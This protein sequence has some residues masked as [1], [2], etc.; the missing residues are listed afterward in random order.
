[1][2]AADTEAKAAAKAA[3]GDGTLQTICR[4]CD[5]HCGINV[6][7][8]NG[9][10]VKITGLKSHPQNEG[11]L[12]PKGPAAIDTVYHKDRLLKPLKKKP[13][14]SFEQI[15]L[16]QAMTEITARMLDIKSKHG[17]RAVACWQGE[18][19]GFA[20]QE[21]YARRFIHAFGSPNFFSCDSL[22]WAGRHLAYSLVQGYWNA[23]PDFLKASL[24]ILWGTNPPVSHSTF[25]GPIKEGRKK[26]AQLIVIDPRLTRIAKQADL[27]LR[28]LPGSDGA[29]AWGLVRHLIESGHHDTEFVRKYST[30]FEQFA[31]YSGVFT[32][33][34]VAGQTGLTAQE[35][36]TCCE[37]VVEHIPRVVNYVGVSIEHQ[38]NGVNSVRTIACLGGLCGAVDIP[39]GD[40]WPEGMGERELSLYDELPLTDQSPVGA[41]K[42][43]VLYDFIKECHTPT[44]MEAML[45]LGD[46]PVKAMILAGGNPA[47]TNPNSAKVARALGSLD[48]FVVRDLFLTETARMAHYVLPAATFLERTELHYYPHYQWVSLSRKVMEIPGVQSEYAFWH[49]L[50]RRLGFGEHYF[51]W[52]TEAEVNRWLLQPTGITLEDLQEHPEGMLYKP[53]EYRK[54]R[55]RPFP[56]PSGKFEFRSRYLEGLGLSALPEYTPP[57]YRLHSEDYPL[58]LIT[59]A[60]KAVYLHS[61]FR[62]IERFRKLHPRAEVEIH[63]QDAARLGIHDNDLVCIESEIGSISMP[64]VVV[65]DRETRP[66]LIQIAHGWEKEGNVNR[67]TLDSVTDP[68]SGFP[69]LT[70]IPVR[71]KLEGCVE[72]A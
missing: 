68:I 52:E 48:L 47:N 17:A 56:T 11:R 41:D 51:P 36:I 71:L 40:L 26:G 58:V 22:C 45:G 30:G 13:D 38:N 18:G 66:G 59:G 23:C 27:H 19:L 10:I 24:I 6:K 60:R 15:S 33:E 54:Y 3:V 65:T 34:Y 49:D 31:A 1:M 50:A 21:K 25:M 70:S 37:M 8:E 57:F 29:L 35:I 55:K 4:Q 42:Y 43:P 53:V 28:P 7:I 62:N 72:G 9:T 46:Y 67:L 39:G 5:M 69:Q 14:G 20:Q 64:A 44:G 2:T 63:P 12:C 32:P 16:D 61:R